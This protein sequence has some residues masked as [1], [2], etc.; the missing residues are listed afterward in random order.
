MVNALHLCTLLIRIM[1]VWSEITCCRKKALTKHHGQF[2]NIHANDILRESPM[3]PPQRE[4]FPTGDILH[5]W[6]KIPIAIMNTRY[7]NWHLDISLKRIKDKFRHSSTHFS[8]CIVPLIPDQFPTQA[9]LMLKKLRTFC[10]C[11]CMG[12]IR[13]IMSTATN[14]SYSYAA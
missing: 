13:F 6:N 8:S 5:D 3:L 9:Q 12:V 14:S 7:F 11:T 10:K 4:E 1:L 2:C